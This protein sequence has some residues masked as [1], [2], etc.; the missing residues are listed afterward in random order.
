MGIGTGTRRAANRSNAKT[1]SVS[2]YQISHAS[3]LLTAK[4]EFLPTLVELNPLTLAL[5]MALLQTIT[6]RVPLKAKENP[7][8]S[9]SVSQSASSLSLFTLKVIILIV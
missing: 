6:A 8:L 2:I 7:E 5:K 4:P 3:F 1:K 9:K